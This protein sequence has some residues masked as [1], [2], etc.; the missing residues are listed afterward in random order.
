MELESLVGVASI[1][2]VIVVLTSHIKGFVKEMR[3]EDFKDQYSEW[4][5]VADIIGITAAILAFYA[6]WLGDFS[7]GRIDNALSAGLF[8]LVVALVTQQGYDLTRRN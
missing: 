6:G 1:P 5:L 2:I 3:D 7:G 4:P 8:G